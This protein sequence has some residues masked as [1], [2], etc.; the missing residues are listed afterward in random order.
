MTSKERYDQKRKGTKR[1]LMHERARGVVRRMRA[2]GEIEIGTMCSR[3]ASLSG[4]MVLHHPDYRLK[5]LVETLCYV[6]HRAEHARPM[7]HGGVT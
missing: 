2:R 6:C 7:P 1:R 4:P 5:R 3:C